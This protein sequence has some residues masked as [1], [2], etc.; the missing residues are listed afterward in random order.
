[1]QELLAQALVALEQHLR[2]ARAAPL[3]A[4]RASAGTH[5]EARHHQVLLSAQA[6]QEAAVA[7]VG[8]AVRQCDTSTVQARPLLQLEAMVETQS[9]TLAQVGVAVAM[10]ESLHQ[11]LPTMFLQQSRQQQERVV[12]VLVALSS[13]PT[14]H[15]ET[16][17]HQ[18]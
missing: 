15:N 6:E 17:I 14:L 12:T 10:L 16:R 5:S 2:V 1:M 9:P 13:L 8:L 7:A 11:A 18:R 4:L 3:L